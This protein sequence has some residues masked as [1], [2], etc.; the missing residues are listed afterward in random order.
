MVATAW[1]TPQA[2]AAEGPFSRTQKPPTTRMQPRPEAANNQG[3]AA[4]NQGDR[5]RRP[6]QTWVMYGVVVLMGALRAHV[7][8]GCYHHKSP[9]VCLVSPIRCGH[10]VVDC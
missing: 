3:G 4:N 6:Q 5:G 10:G 7:L 1:P 8:S 2:T 9:A